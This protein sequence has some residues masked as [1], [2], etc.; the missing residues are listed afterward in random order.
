VDAAPIEITVKA[1]RVPQ[2]T[3]EE[4]QTVGNL[5]ISPVETDEPE[6]TIRMIPL[7]CARLRIGC[8]PVADGVRP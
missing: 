4:N 8:L 2:W 1:R 7:G 6:E 5:P 3:L